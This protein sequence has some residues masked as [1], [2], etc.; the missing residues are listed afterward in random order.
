MLV[1]LLPCALIE[2]CIGLDV[3]KGQAEEK[4]LQRREGVRNQGLFGEQ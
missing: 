3:H 4:H 1:P 2:V